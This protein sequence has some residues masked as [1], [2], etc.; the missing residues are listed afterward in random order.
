ML[1]G[2][3]SYEDKIEG[4]QTGVDTF[5]TKPFSPKELRIYISNLIEQRE[6]LRAK[7]KNA[8]SI[9]PD[10]IP[11]SSIDKVFLEKTIQLIRINLDNPSFSVEELAE[12]MCLS[13]S[14]LHRKLQALIDQAPGQLLR[15]MRLQKAVELLNLKSGSM[16]DICYQTGFND[17]AYFSR[18]FK[19]QF[20]CS[21]T[22]FKKERV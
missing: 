21:P 22:A 2:K 20:G 14:Q 11:A 3:A 7:Y 5:L 9:F 4:L 18:A 1:T 16:A 10:E 6:K 15:N 13:S 19:K 8:F 17:Q 12:K